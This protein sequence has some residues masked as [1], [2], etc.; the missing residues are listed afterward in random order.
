[1]K[2]TG[3]EST[4]NNRTNEEKTERSEQALEKY[5]QANLDG[6]LEIVASLY[7]SSGILHEQEKLRK[8][9]P[10]L[11]STDMNYIHEPYWSY[12]FPQLKAYG[13]R[14]VKRIQP[15]FIDETLVNTANG[16]VNVKGEKIK[17]RP[18]REFGR[19]L[20]LLYLQEQL[21]KTNKS[22][23]AVPRLFIVPNNV[24]DVHF[25]FSLPYLDK[26]HRRLVLDSGSNILTVES[27]SF[28]IY[29]EYIEGSGYVGDMSFM[30]YGHTDFNAKQV[31]KSKKTEKNYLIDTKEGKNFFIAPFN[32]MKDGFYSYWYMNAGRSLPQNP[33]EFQKWQLTQQTLIL[34]A[35]ALHFPIDL[36]NMDVNIG[37]LS[38]LTLDE[39]Q[40]PQHSVMFDESEPYFSEPELNLVRYLK[41]GRYDLFLSLLSKDPNQSVF[42]V[43]KP[44]LFNPYKTLVELMLDLLRHS[45]LENNEENSNNICDILDIL[46]PRIKISTAQE[47]L[48]LFT[49]IASKREDHSVNKLNY[50]RGAQYLK[51]L[52]KNQE[53]PSE[54]LLL[55]AAISKDVVEHQDMDLLEMVLE[56]SNRHIIES[57]VNEMLAPS[58]MGPFSKVPEEQ[59]RIPIRSLLNT[60]NILSD[61]TV[62]RIFT[63]NKKDLIDEI[64]NK[65]FNAGS[66]LFL[67]AGII[68]EPSQSH[69]RH[70]LG[71][72]RDVNWYWYQIAKKI[73]ARNPPPED[74][75]KTIAYALTNGK[76]LLLELMLKQ[77]PVYTPKAD[78]VIKELLSS[79]YHGNHIFENAIQSQSI[80][81]ISMFLEHGK[82]IEIHQFRQ[83]LQT[84]NDDML[85]V[86]IR[87]GNLQNPVSALK[88]AIYYR[89][90]N[91]IRLL[92][93]DK[94]NI[95]GDV[96]FDAI[97]TKDE[98]VIN[99]M[100]DALSNVKSVMSQSQVDQIFKDKKAAKNL[101]ESKI[102][103]DKA[104]FSAV[105]K[106]DDPC[107]TQIRF[108]MNNKRPIDYD[109][110]EF[111]E[112][113]LEKNPSEAGIDQ[114]TAYALNNSKI[115]ILEKL[116]KMKPSPSPKTD[117]I[118]N[119]ILNSPY[120]GDLL[121]ENAIKANGKCVVGLLL[122]H[123]KKA[124]PYQCSLAY[125]PE[126]KE[127]LEAQYL[128][129]KRRA[130]KKN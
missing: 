47:Q 31:I 92:V 97:M 57:L 93:K 58:L 12:N 3:P 120:S 37:K 124:T 90:I 96:C 70:L 6:N 1:M 91:A 38:E 52:L 21:A 49:L 56:Y 68:D 77:K 109:W 72:S 130:L 111:V 87:S 103:L 75:D 18:I 76:V 114:A 127:L 95:T 16:E 51:H 27:D 59:L 33:D 15:Y 107:H 61:K 26:E 85:S 55:Q 5:I 63:L 67:V 60:L 30:Y 10:G 126:M 94:K 123:G 129:S 44:E 74:I 41:I 20:P 13:Q 14:I 17:V 81:L 4:K 32:P 69:I 116:L 29:Q 53:N 115:S 45:Y 108:I 64:F 25:N 7:E 113:I 98:V 28:T 24:E 119:D 89:N 125:E 102:D 99:I 8:A 40:V 86:M 71:K 39:V 79:P 122:S 62:A 121:L 2:R 83:A 105:E 84:R 11:Y 104:L 19:V 117:K 36:K 118:L 73:L 80:L 35:K 54:E 100:R 22:N 34:R 9:S 101:I 78:E 65:E 23:L 50:A 112:S 106:I 66:A 46:I 110:Y 42:H 48:K 88:E 82:S 128:I 43:L